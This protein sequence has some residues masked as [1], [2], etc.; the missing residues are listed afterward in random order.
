MQAPQDSY[1]EIRKIF[2]SQTEWL[3][4]YSD[5]TSLTSQTSEIELE[6]KTDKLIFG[7]L[8]KRGFQFWRI[9]DWK[10]EKGKLSFELTR[11]FN[12][13]KTKIEIV[14]RISANEFTENLEM[15]RLEKAVK[16]ANL[17]IENQAPAKLV[18][19]ELNKENGR[20]A[21]IIFEKPGAGQ[22][23]V[24]ADVS[25]TLTP[26]VLLTSAI[27]RLEKLQK[28]KKNSIE[29]IWIVAERKIARKLQKLHALLRENWQRKIRIWEISGLFST[30]N[31]PQLDELRKL[32]LQSL[33]RKNTKKKQPNHSPALSR[34]AVK[35]IEIAPEEI[36]A[37]QTKNGE[38]LY[39][40]GLPFARI[41]RILDGE[42]IWFGVES[43]RRFLNGSNFGE[44]AKLIDELKIYRQH[45]SPNKQHL[46]YKHAPEAWLESIL[47]KNIK[48]LDANLILAPLYNQFRAGQDRLDLLAL[49]RDGQLAVIEVKVSPDREIIFQSVDYW[50][51]IEA[52]R[53][54]GSLQKSKIFGDLVIRD[55]PA[56]VYLVAPLFSYH[57]DF[58]LLVQTIAP[59]IEIYRFDINENWRESL[60][61]IR[62]KRVTE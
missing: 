50:H 54:C 59:E 23:A 28:R 41:R 26:E 18:R 1:N 31:P 34:T 45:N 16:I 36:D 61:I 11:N 19:A 9:T 27:L 47:R 4:I 13:E 43:E 58:S 22:T 5:G 56:L 60:K 6:L 20:F 40:R 14:P 37:K 29:K 53:R 55:A 46:F 2:N 39:F 57:K 10:Y 42:R 12:R 8:N 3:F 49:R 21:Q 15:A 51:K 33:Y 35:I 48:L 17:I 52:E 44:F 7:F 25:E 62:Q 24:L 32:D 30:E 38:T